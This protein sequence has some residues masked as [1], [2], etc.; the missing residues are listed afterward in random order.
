[1]SDIP[2]PRAASTVVLLRDTP[3]GMKVL[4]L[5]ANSF[6]TIAVGVAALVAVLKIAFGG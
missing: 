2:Q 1:M 4:L 6:F 3:S 5:M